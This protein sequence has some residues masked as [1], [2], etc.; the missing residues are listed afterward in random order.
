MSHTLKLTHYSGLLLCSDGG[1]LFVPE[2]YKTVQDVCN[3]GKLAELLGDAPTQPEGQSNKDFLN[4]SWKEVE[5][6]EKQRETLKKAVA[7]GCEGSIR[8]HPALN[9]LLEQLGLTE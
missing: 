3:A 8:P 9:A 4:G 2:F 7:K 5:I 1:L 6:S